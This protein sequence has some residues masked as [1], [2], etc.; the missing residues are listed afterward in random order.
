MET[1]KEDFERLFVPSVISGIKDQID[2]EILNSLTSR[3]EKIK[4]NLDS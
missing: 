1:F 3:L 2:P 4:A